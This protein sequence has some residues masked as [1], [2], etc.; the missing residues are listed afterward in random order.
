M[1]T[2]VMTGLAGLITQ[3]PQHSVNTSAYSIL[4]VSDDAL[5]Y[6]RLCNAQDVELNINHAADLQ[7][8]CY[9]ALAAV[10]SKVRRSV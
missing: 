6:L 5:L 9:D 3:M 4:A 10:G 8:A 7:V 1:V 2:S